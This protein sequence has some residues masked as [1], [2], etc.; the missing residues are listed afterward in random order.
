MKE[1][2]D[3]KIKLKESEVSLK[4]I[5]EMFPSGILFYNKTNGVFYKNKYCIIDEQKM[6]DI[7]VNIENN[8]KFKRLRDD[9]LAKDNKYL[10]FD[11]LFLKDSSKITLKDEIEY[12]YETIYS[13][14]DN[15]HIDQKNSCSLNQLSNSAHHS[16]PNEYEV[17]DKL[18]N[19]IQEFNVKFSQI[20]ISDYDNVLMIVLN[21][22]SEKARVKEAKLS[23][24]L[25][26]VMLCSISHELRSPANQINGVLSLLKPT[27]T[28]SQQLS[29]F[30][31]ATSSTEILCTKINDLLDY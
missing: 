1:N 17:R 5:L 20:K 24:K 11:S 30:H 21:D 9:R 8:S 3:G 31:I 18:G 4:N 28:S 2:I 16:S 23:E 22:I 12:I 27:L 13:S 19:I 29:L 7:H 26:T 10:I 25:K 15:L 14:S 6:I